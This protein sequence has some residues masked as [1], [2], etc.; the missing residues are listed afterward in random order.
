MINGK[1]ENFIYSGESEP[2]WF[3]DESSFRSVP[4][5]FVIDELELQYNVTVATE[6]VDVNQLFT[7]SFSHKNLDIALKAITIPVNLQYE[8]NENKIVLTVEGK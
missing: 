5:K 6:D 4:L 7:G 1:E 3:H 8:I 2:D